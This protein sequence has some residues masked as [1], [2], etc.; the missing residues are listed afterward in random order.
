MKLFFYNNKIYQYFFFFIIFLYSVINGGNSNLLIQVNF[1]IVSSFFFICIFKKNYKS[2]L[3]Y[4]FKKNKISIIFFF[5]F[6]LFIVFQLIPLPLEILKFF[7]KEKYLIIKKM[8]ILNEKHS[9]SLSTSNTFFQFLNFLT[10]FLV[11]LICKMIFY[12]TRHIYRYYVFISS[13]GAFCSLIALIF[14]LNGNKDFFFISNFK[15]ISSS[16]GFFINSTVFSI[17][18]VFCF[19]GS[20]EVLK[21]NNDSKNNFY[22]SFYLKIYIRLFILLITI[23]IITTFS[24]LGNFLFISSIFFYLINEIFIKK[25]RNNNNFLFLMIMVIIFDIAFLGFYFGSDR[26]LQRFYFLQ[27]E[28]INTQNISNNIT[29]GNLISFSFEQ[30]KDFLFFG[31]GGGSFETLFQLK[32]ESLTNRYADHSHS[33][34]IEFIG[35]YGLFGNILLLISLVSF[36]FDKQSYTFV[37]ITLFFFIIIILI[38]DFSM[39]VPI[40]Q[41]LFIIFLLFNKKNFIKSYP[42]S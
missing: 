33:D 22:E 38:F 34:L 35:E 6:L 16:T 23:G 42:S 25:K 8:T 24:R 9:L 31:Y 1:L 32:Y 3:N 15:N 20:L 40:I 39:H 2:H 11:I 30:V 7:S 29:R 14:F 10:L 13:L 5:L 18:L 27:N 36:F 4:F 17:F 19:I 41:I 12:K 21:S 26:L 37:N 28:L